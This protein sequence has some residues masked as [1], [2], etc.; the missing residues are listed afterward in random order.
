[1]TIF[2]LRA[3]LLSSLIAV[4]P[5]AQAETPATPAAAPAGFKLPSGKNVSYYDPEQKQITE[6]EFLKLMKAGSSFSMQKVMVEGDDPIIKMKLDK[7][8]EKKSMPAPKYKI[9]PGDPFPAFSLPRLIGKPIDNKVLMGKYTIVSFYF[10]DCAPCITEIPELNA[11]SA[12]R[13]DMNFIGMTFDPVP[14]TRKFVETHKLTWTLLSDA[15]KTLTD[16]G[17]NHF[18]SFALID[19]Q[20]KLVALEPGHSIQKNDK[21]LAAWVKRVAPAVQ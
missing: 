3:V 2:P 8:G 21:S 15:R 14:V 17:I 5:A 18:P 4:V 1:M 7:P 11:F 19:P 13:E 9:K 12:G 10:A 16:V 20:G 6:E